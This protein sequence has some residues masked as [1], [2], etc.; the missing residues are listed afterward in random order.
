MQIPS[1]FP[2]K[3]CFLD[4]WSSPI[5]SSDSP[6]VPHPRLIKAP[7][8]GHDPPA[9]SSPALIWDKAERICE[10]SCLFSCDD[11]RVFLCSLLSSMFLTHFFRC[12][13]PSQDKERSQTL[14]F[15]SPRQRS[16]LISCP[17]RTR[18]RLRIIE[19]S[20]PKDQPPSKELSFL[21]KMLRGDRCHKKTPSQ[22]HDRDILIH[23]GCLLGE[24]ETEKTW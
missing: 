22:I 9:E 7:E 23:P 16:S 24:A 1:A 4:L 20:N 2:H 21:L 12:A 15:I 17:T 6:A 5:L 13:T 14:L 19:I 18:V 3:P 11:R 8:T 10:Y